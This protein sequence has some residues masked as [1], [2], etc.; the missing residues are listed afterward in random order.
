MGENKMNCQNCG[1]NLSGNE[2]VC[3]VCGAAVAQQNAYD[4]NVYV[5]QGYDPNAY[6]QQMYAQ[7]MYAQPARPEFDPN[8]LPEQYRP[9]SAWAYFGLQLLYSVPIVGFI[10]LIIFSFNVGNVHRRSHARSQWIP[11]IIVLTLCIVV[12]VFAFLGMTKT[13]VMNY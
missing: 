4:Q 7:Q 11:A 3:P 8:T 10:F 5:Q 2:Q 6:A 13:A 12:F 1:Y 9:L